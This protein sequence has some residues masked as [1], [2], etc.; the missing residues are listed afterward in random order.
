MKKCEWVIEIFEKQ[1]I[2]RLVKVFTISK[3]NKYLAI[4]LRF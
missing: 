3:S 4:K 2:L 1:Y